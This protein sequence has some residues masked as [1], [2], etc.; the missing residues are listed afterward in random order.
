MT[1]EQFLGEVYSMGSK[2]IALTLAVLLLAGC[3]DVSIKATDGS[4]STMSGSMTNGSMSYS[5]GPGCTPAQPNPQTALPVTPPAALTSRQVCDANGTNCKMMLMGDTPPECMT[6]VASVKGV[7]LT[8][9]GAWALAGAA[10]IFAMVA[11]G[12]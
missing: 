1:P 3:T 6:Q 2:I 9:Y 11:I 8:T 10:A 12:S 7:D 4:G 5:A